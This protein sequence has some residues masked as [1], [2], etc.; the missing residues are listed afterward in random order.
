MHQ[1]S[2]AL[3]TA[4]SLC[5]HWGNPTPKM[6]HSPH[7]NPALISTWSK[8]NKIVFTVL[9]WFVVKYSGSRRF[10]TLIKWLMNYMFL[11][12]VLARGFLGRFKVQWL[13]PSTSMAM[14]L[15][16]SGR[17]IT[18]ATSMEKRPSSVLDTWASQTYWLALSR[19]MNQIVAISG[20]LLADPENILL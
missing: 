18:S 5:H 9:I 14:M 3:G 2:G 16:V 11:C 6:A 17:C 15:P 12:T 20:Q 8:N 4:S 7:A 1:K 13:G 10:E 19:A